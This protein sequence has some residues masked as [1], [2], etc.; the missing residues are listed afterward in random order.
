[1]QLGS[2]QHPPDCYCKATDHIEEML[3]F[4]QALYDK[5]FAYRIEGD[6]IYFDVTKLPD[7]GKPLV[8]T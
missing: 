6:G 5:G 3:E 2:P 1:M 8:R 4:V 7:Y